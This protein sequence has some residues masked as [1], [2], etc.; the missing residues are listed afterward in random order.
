[1][2]TDVD[3]HDLAA[4]DTVEVVSA[5][6]AQRVGLRAKVDSFRGPH[7]WL[8]LRWNEHE[9]GGA[10]HWLV[11]GEHVRFVQRSDHDCALCAVVHVH[12]L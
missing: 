11:K 10:N 6:S 3:G 12:G 5:D 7:G 1:M 2:V 8:D 4:G 9:S